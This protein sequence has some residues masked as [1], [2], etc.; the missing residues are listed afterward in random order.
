VIY[1]W[2]VTKCNL[3]IIGLIFGITFLPTGVNAVTLVVNQTPCSASG[4]SYYGTV[5]DA[6]NAANENDGI[7]VCQ[8]T[9]TENL[10]VDKPLDVTSDSGVSVTILNAFDA[11]DH[12]L[13]VTANNVNVSGFSIQGSTGINAA[14]VYLEGADGGNI[15][16]NKITNNA[17]GILL[18]GSDNNV[19]V[20][21]EITLNKFAGVYLVGSDNNTIANN[22]VK[23]NDYSGIYLTGSDNNSITNNTATY[24]ELYYGIGLKASHNN[25]VEGNNAS[26]N[27][28]GFYIHN[29]QGNQILQSTASYNEYYGLYL[30]ATE[31]DFSEGCEPFCDPWWAADPVNCSCWPASPPIF[32][33]PNLIDYITAS[34]NDYGIVVTNT[35]AAY[36]VSN[37]NLSGN[38]YWGLYSIFNDQEIISNLNIIGDDDGLGVFSVPPYGVRLLVDDTY[39]ATANAKYI[40]SLDNL[41]LKTDTFDFTVTNDNGATYQFDDGTVQ[42]KPGETI[43]RELIVSGSVGVEYEIT[44]KVESQNDPTVDDEIE[45]TTLISES[46]YIDPTSNVDGLS[47]VGDS[48]IYN[49]NITNSTLIDSII[50][51]SSVTNSTLDSVRL[52]NGVVNNNLISSGN[53]TIGGVI[54]EITAPISL[55]ELVVIAGSEDNTLVGVNGTALNV[56]VG[57]SNIAVSI[58]ADGDYIGGS[59][60]I[61]SSAVQ[62][63]GTSAQ[64]NNVGG[65]SNILV[66][67]NLEA[68]M[69][70]TYI[71]ISYDEADLGDV[72]ESTLRLQFYN[73]TS[74]A[75]ENVTLSGVNETG[76]YVWVFIPH[77]SVFG[78][79]GNIKSSGKTTSPSTTTARSSRKSGGEP[80][81]PPVISTSGSTSISSGDV[82]D[83]I[84][85]FNYRSAHFFVVASELA[86]SFAALNKYPTTQTLVDVINK[87]AYR[88]VKNLDGDIY[89][90][91]AE[92]AVLNGDS[93]EVFISRGDLGVDSCAAAAYA[94]ALGVPILLTYPNEMHPQTEAALKQLGTQKVIILGGNDAVSEEI[95]NNLPGVTRIG[96]ENRYETAV[97]IAEALMS[98]KNV[99][100]IVIT[101]GENPDVTSVMIAVYYDAPIV[102]TKGNELPPETKAFL[103]SNTFNK[104]IFV[105]VPQ[106]VEGK[107][108]SI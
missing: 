59:M 27:L 103:E 50:T 26:N 4:D 42:L 10:D 90:I 86:G 79:H 69:N 101:D 68:N 75:W 28:Y 94:H 19:I 51:N 106:N 13:N 14:G 45:T 16:K 24:N 91:A 52:T 95:E 60:S 47:D 49:S 58:L 40:V 18:N 81:I 62:P 87:V 97:K 44:I 89:S 66:S 30:S 82:G 73:E 107:I 102:Y 80:S 3:L 8:G 92:H 2:R 17:Y 100:T 85:Q 20:N 108:N 93:R 35:T 88:K 104:V 31:C 6:I 5:T 1:G 41:G 21:N 67:E 12:V 105:G 96:G 22:T 77:F 63:S 48:G 34:G 25:T 71:E 84:K 61:Q 11:T 64:E 74:L 7:I 76:N 32:H 29:S 56:T 98:T 15:S 37:A 54:Y 83:L 46:P 65:Y 9:Y 43:N 38:Y 57:E 53:I 70:Y 72:N 99:D 36:K 55:S 39:R 78:L 33:N 23:S